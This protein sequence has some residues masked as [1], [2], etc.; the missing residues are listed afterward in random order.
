MAAHDVASVLVMR[1]R[2]RSSSVRS[3]YRVTPNSAIG[4]FAFS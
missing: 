3:A 4:L 1:R 2:L